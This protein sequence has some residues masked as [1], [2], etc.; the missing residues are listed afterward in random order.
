M[1]GIVVCSLFTQIKT[2][3][4]GGIILKVVNGTLVPF[5]VDTRLLDFREVTYS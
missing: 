1:L 5:M 3:P 4:H 2:C